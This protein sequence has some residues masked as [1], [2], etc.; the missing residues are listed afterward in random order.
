MATDLIAD[1]LAEL[2]GQVKVLAKEYYE[3]TGKPLG[4]TGEVGEFE[5]ARL[6]GVRLRGPRHPGHDALRLSQNGQCHLSIKSVRLP[7]SRE[8][9]WRIGAIDL[10]AQWD[11]VLLVLLDLD[12]EPWE[13]WEAD[14]EA[15][16]ALLGSR[17]RT[18]PGVRE[19]KK[20][21]RCVW[22]RAASKSI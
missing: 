22:P 14:R 3:L 10:G 11:A 8:A 17:S 7:P 5:A 6:L 4:V 19:F 21:G 18:D 15:L 9:S 12:F 13:I 2:L 16:T 1:R 20:I